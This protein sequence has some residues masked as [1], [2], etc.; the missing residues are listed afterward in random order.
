MSLMKA[1][2]KD[3]LA[4]TKGK[5]LNIEWSQFLDEKLTLHRLT[6]KAEN[7]FL[8]LDVRWMVQSVPYSSDNPPLI[9]IFI[10]KV[11]FLKHFVLKLIKAIRFNNEYVNNGFTVFLLKSKMFNNMQFVIPLCCLQNIAL[12]FIAIPLSFHVVICDFFFLVYLFC[13]Y[14]HTHAKKKPNI[15]QN[16]HHHGSF[17][18]KSKTNHIKDSLVYF[19]HGP[20]ER[21]SCCWQV[22]TME[23]WNSQKCSQMDSF[24]LLLVKMTV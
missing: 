11:F 3:N 21:N 2:H 13:W 19:I 9:S 22:V 14:T 7:A 12:I 20:C 23:W 16:K 6:W 4:S 15:L 17:F 5:E 18:W 24:R 8:H 1:W 10:S